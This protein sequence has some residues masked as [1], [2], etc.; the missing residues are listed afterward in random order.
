FQLHDLEAEAVLLDAGLSET[1][2]RVLVAYT[3]HQLVLRV[4]DTGIKDFEA[5]MP[6]GR[7][8]PS[9]EIRYAFDDGLQLRMG[10]PYHGLRQIGGG[11][12]RDLA[13]FVDG[14]PRGHR[15]F[16]TALTADLPA[17]TGGTGPMTTGTSTKVK[18]DSTAG[19][20]ERG[21][22]RIGQEILE[23]TG[24]EDNTFLV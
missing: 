2:D 9:G 5:R 24:K 1:E 6:K 20:P 15:S 18:V 11:R 21:T 10:A 7:A 3:G 23:Y 8:P 17:D 22:L 14:V 19:F 16:T 12:D 13:L 4:D